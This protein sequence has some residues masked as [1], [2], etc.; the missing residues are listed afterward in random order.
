MKCEVCGKKFDKVKWHKPFNLC[1]SSECFSRKLWDIRAEKYKQDPF[2]IIDGCAY[3][4]AGYVKH[5]KPYQFLGFDGREFNIR[6]NDGT[7]I[8]TNNL[9]FGGNIPES[10]R[11]LLPDNAV[12]VK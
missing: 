10:H 6:M 2:I 9:W 12:F 8:F 1:C 3:S 11:A 7:E 5:P 4:D